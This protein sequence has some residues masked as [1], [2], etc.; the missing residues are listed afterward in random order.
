MKDCIQEVKNRELSSI[1][2]NLYVFANFGKL[3]E[4]P[5]SGGQT[6]AR[7][8]MNGLESLGYQVH[9]IVKHRSELKGK[10]AHQ[11]EVLF[12]AMADV[13][14]IFFT[15]L[16]KRRKQSAFMMLTYAGSLV[17]FE[18]IITSIVRCLG[19]KCIYYLKGGKL[20]DTYESG[21]RL[22]KWM[23]KRTMDMESLVFFEGMNCLYMVREMTNTSLAFFPNYIQD[24]QL[25]EYHTKP[26]EPIGILYF[27]RVTP[28]KNVH[29]SL[30]AF[31]LLCEKHSNLKLTI[32]GSSTRAVNYTKQIEKLI[33][34]S[35]YSDRICK[36][37][38]SPFEV[39]QDAMK[40]HHFFLFPTHEQAE[41][42]SNSLTEAMSCGLVPIV[43]DWHFN[44]DIVGNDRLVVTGYEAKDYAERI[45]GV[46][47][48]GQ[49]ASF[50]QQMY[51]R[52]NAQFCE[53]AVLNRIDKELQKIGV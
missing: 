3:T 7:R 50:S 28:D 38:N 34:A 46:I 1:L 27:G 18:F 43:S 20:L 19:F 30:E 51:K 42:H 52:V 6:S 24:Q 12:F 4:L 16:L 35:P 10:V 48:S 31:N 44:R 45:D 47:R 25:S 15:L 11:I 8:V 29:V 5:K 49:W 53:K 22:H 33:T 40:S 41:G 39:I 23:F 21:S 2:M 13:L 26:S 14:K 9:P 37:G 36:L 17:P 32:I